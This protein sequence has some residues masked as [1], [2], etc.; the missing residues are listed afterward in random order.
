MHRRAWRWVTGMGLVGLL[1]AC[2][3]GLA[4]REFIGRWEGVVGNGADIP[5]EVPLFVGAGRD[6]VNFVR[7]RFQLS[8]EGKCSYEVGLDDPPSTNLNEDCTYAVDGSTGAIGITLDG[9]YV[10][11]GTIEGTTMT[12]SWPNAGGQPNIFEYAKE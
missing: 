6:T 8:T 11:S 7:S 2:A 4:P 5:G 12:L 3:E 9:D 10:I 1:L